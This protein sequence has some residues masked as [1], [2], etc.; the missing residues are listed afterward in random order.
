MGFV[1]WF[2]EEVDTTIHCNYKRSFIIADAE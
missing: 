1:N 2:E